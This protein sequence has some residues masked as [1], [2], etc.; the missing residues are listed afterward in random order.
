MEE[1]GYNRVEIG[2]KLNDGEYGADVYDDV[3]PFAEK[4]GVT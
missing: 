2:A 1:A 3:K 4:A